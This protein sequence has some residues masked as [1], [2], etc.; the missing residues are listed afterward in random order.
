[1]ILPHTNTSVLVLLFLCMLCWGSWPV[2]FKMARKYRFELF[3]FDF[4]FGLV[5]AALIC[6][7][8]AGSWGYDGFG[9]KDD[10][11]N[12]RKQEWLLAFL[13]AVIFNFGNMFTMA[14][15]S[16]AGMTL[17][18]PVA[19]GIALFA[20][21][22]MSYLGQSG[23]DGTLLTGGTVLILA[24]TVLNCSAYSR[25][26]LLQHEALARAGKTRSTRR[27]SAVK[28]I[29]L[30]LIG[31]LALGVFGPMLT[32]A[33]DPDDG[34]GPYAVLVLFAVGVAFSTFVFNLFFMNLPV[35]GDPLE[36][37]DYFKGAIRN[38]VLGI[39][40]GA[41]WGIGA[42]AAFVAATPKGD[43]HPTGAWATLPVAAAPLVAALWG[44]LV[45]KEY[46]TRD[47]RVKALAAVMLLLFAGGV[48]LFSYGTVAKP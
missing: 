46:R 17:A 35:E 34:V 19:F 14:A 18:M 11:I 39:S 13:A 27:P 6:A 45:W 36:I 43:T 5:I 37:T 10:L 47:T 38:H 29:L 7:F 4:A 1:M 31:G 44:L 21:S 40:A 32:R 25:L 26:R 15:I 42:L 12:A 8:T 33:Q 41:V 23:L 30:A 2:F 24:S 20:G 3:Y 16:V 22:W 48:V 9:F 28:G